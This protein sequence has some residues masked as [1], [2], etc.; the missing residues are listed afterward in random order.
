M[1]L[2]ARTLLHIRKTGGTAIKT[3]LRPHVDGCAIVLGKH[4]L[5]LVDVPAGERAFF[6]VRHPCQRFVSGFN[7][8]SRKGQPRNYIEWTDAEAWAFGRFKTPNALAEALSSEDQASRG[9]AERAMLGI[10]HTGL[11][12][13]YWLLSASYVRK[14]EADIVW[15]GHQPT[16]TEDFATLTTLLGLPGNVA[17]PDDDVDAHRTPNG[18]E[19]ELSPTGD[20]NIAHWYRKDFEIYAACLELRERLLGRP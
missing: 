15:V 9:D 13:S 16:L 12:L 3:A 8:R 7:S 11:K 5:T 6:C 14:R 19:T 18:Y 1:T 10:A 17:L 2:P 4:D 20:A